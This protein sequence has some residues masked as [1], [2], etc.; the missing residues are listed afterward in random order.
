MKLTPQLIT[1]AAHSHLPKGT[2]QQ[3]I[4]K[5]IWTNKIDQEIGYSLRI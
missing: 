1:P 3:V 2:N 4:Q 5:Q